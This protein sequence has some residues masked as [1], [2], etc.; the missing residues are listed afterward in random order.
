M[1]L[2][3]ASA[4]SATVRSTARHHGAQ[5]IGLAGPSWLGERG[6]NLPTQKSVVTVAIDGAKPLDLPAD[7]AGQ[8]L[9]VYDALA[10]QPG[11][12]CQGDREHCVGDFEQVVVDRKKLASHIG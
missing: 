4:T 7:V 10:D 8:L 9:A 2:V 12:Q 1:C 6:S 5:P 11:E 3:H